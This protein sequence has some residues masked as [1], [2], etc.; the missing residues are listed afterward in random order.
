MPNVFTIPASVPFAETLAR[1]LISRVGAGR[2]PLALANITL[3]LP[4]RRAA[5]TMND[6]FARVLGGAALLPSVRPLGDVEEEDFLFDA[7]AEALSLPPAISPIRRVLLLATLI[8]RWD[9]RRRPNGNLTYAQAVAMSRGLAAFQDEAETQEVDLNDLGKLAPKPLAHHWADVK[10]FLELIRDEWPGVLAGERKMNPAA[11]RNLAL[12][13]LAKRLTANPPPG[14][15]VGAGSTGSIPATALLLKAIAA[16]PDGFVVLPGLD[17]ELDEG[18]WG[19]LDAGHPQYGLKQLL[20]RMGLSRGDVVEFDSSSPLKARERL[21]REVLRPA[22]TTDAWRAIAERGS[23]E[24]AKGLEGLSV[25]EAADPGEEAAAIALMLRH[26]LSRQGNGRED[27]NTAALITPDRN[28]ARRVASEMRRWNIDVDDSA[29]QPLANTPPGTFLCL[30][31]EAAAEAFAPVPL[32]SLL[33]HPLAAGGQAPAEFRRRVRQLDR[34]CL[35]G[36]RPDP[37]LAG[38]AKAIQAALEKAQA[39]ERKYDIEAVATLAYWF[40]PIAEILQPLED[41]FS[42]RHAALDAL[43]RAHMETAAQ[44]SATDSASGETR[45]WRGQEGEIAAQFIADLEEAAADLP[46]MEVSSYP[47]LFRGLAQERA[48][49]PAYG[50]HPRLSILGPLEARL[51]S[52]DLVVLG[53]LNEGAWPR[54]AETDPWLSRPMRA[55][56]GLEPP[57]RRI[58]LSAHDFSIL[59]SAPKVLLT[60]A[61]KSDGAPAVASRWLQRLQQLTKG[62]GLEE[63]LA[64]VTPYAALAGIRDEPEAP[65]P[66]TERPRPRPPVAARPRRLSVTEIE[67]WLRDPYAIY[68]KHVLGLQPLDDLDAEIGPLERGSAIHNALERFLR[69]MP[70]MPDGA[71]KELIL[72]AD[73]IFAAARLPLAALVLWRPRLIHAAHWFVM[74]ERIRRA[75]VAASHL[76]IKGER[77]FAA[78]AGDFVLRAR[79]DRIDLLNDGSAAILDYKTGSLPTVKQVRTLLTPQLPL[80]GAILNGG[81]FR[82]ASG[83]STSELT[84]IRFGGGAE[85]GE[86]RNIPDAAGLIREAEAKL[87]ARIA[88]FDNEDTPYLPR[89]IPFRADRPG[90]YDHLSRVREWAISGW[91]EPEE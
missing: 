25:V 82:E 86:I 73:E 33:K 3:Y 16:L 41:A 4:T 72:I 30:L 37:G 52:F 60:R 56:L 39:L 26:A 8:Q 66:R 2:D 46:E 64:C 5:R 19:A 80:E 45:L 70:D 24:I 79:A 53:G 63:G 47:V 67:T 14:L 35:R 13:S 17:K 81:G 78:P 27:W 43:L 21:L 88:E 61:L 74:E 65:L 76:E 54:A 10:R 9:G 62:L 32:L 71:E 31:A 91:E 42:T 28:L 1:G 50:K 20:G 83:I 7:G 34:L 11:R 48:V 75:H 77:A 59:A 12:S 58:G 68:A 87:R 55:Q 51:Q 40:K 6:V 85:P 36:P 29:G 69:E 84:Y 38:V 57:E 22:P 15:V 18:A 89:L 23:G 44:L 90:D 49:R